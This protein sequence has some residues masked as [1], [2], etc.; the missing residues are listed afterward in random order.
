[1]NYAD[2]LQYASTGSVGVARACWQPRKWVY[3][4]RGKFR[5]VTRGVESVWRPSR[6]DQEADDWV[7]K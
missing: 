1:M 3:Y 5:L 6:A 2:A 4:S 7:V